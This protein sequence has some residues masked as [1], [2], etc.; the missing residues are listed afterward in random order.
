M[1]AL[2]PDHSL[3]DVV[4]RHRAKPS[5]LP[6]ESELSLASVIELVRRY[7]LLVGVWM[8]VTLCLAALTILNL[9]TWFKA[10]GILALDSRQMQIS[11]LNFNNSKSSN[12][13]DSNFV[14]TEVSIISSDGIARRVI[15]E[16]NLDKAPEFMAAPSRSDRLLSGLASLLDGCCG[17]LKPLS[18]S[19]R[20]AQSPAEFPSAE[21]QLNATLNT[22][23]RNLQVSNDGR[24]YIINLSFTSPNASLARNIVNRHS[25]AYIEAQREAKDRQLDST[26]SWLNREVAQLADRLA[27]AEIS[28]QDYRAQNHLLSSS[29][30][31]PVLQQ[32][33]TNTTEQLANAESELARRQ[34]RS[35]SREGAGGEAEIARQ[36]RD[37][38]QRIVGGLEENLERLQRNQ[39]G[40][41]QLERETFAQ[42]SLYESLLGRQKAIE[43]Q[44]G[45]QQADAYVVSSAELPRVPYYPNRALLMALAFMLSA[46]SGTAIAFLH[47]RRRK[48]FQ[49]LE[50]VQQTLG[51]RPLASIP[52]LG[53]KAQRHRPV[54]LSTFIFDQPRSEAAESVR[55]LRNAVAF[56]RSQAQHVIAVSSFLPDEGK[57]SV[58]LALARGLAGPDCRVLFIEADL[59]RPAMGQFLGLDTSRGGIVAVLTG[60]ARLKD[61]VISDC[62]PDLDILPV[63]TNVAN[64]QDLLVP[65]C[66]GRLI[67]QAR[68]SYA[69]IVVDTPPLGAVSDALLIA[70]SVETTI[71]IIR[72][73]TT[74]RSSVARATQGFLAAGFPIIGAVLNFAES[75]YS[76]RVG[77]DKYY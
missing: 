49:S 66:F 9:R 58:A 38:L 52:Q 15:R 50:E 27:K 43:T 11:E 59:H 24:S 6:T 3:E 47:D 75:N 23:L 71:L 56:Q 60:A 14:R 20:R 18:D 28:V 34:S 37:D 67:A 22:Y 12:S 53:K 63:E 68:Q 39:L 62:T 32:Q 44:V 69:F 2:I 5:D 16:L 40:V 72:A 73:G 57:T 4:S 1:N 33:L 51:L 35:S 61:R 10:E 70:A 48:G 13:L 45:I 77:A 30:I 41:Q 19:L 7:R 26:T 55:T 64:P 36:N 74:P 17:F 46:G 31:E 65:A 54:A 21:D 25:Q 8:A 76:R 42:R 29:K